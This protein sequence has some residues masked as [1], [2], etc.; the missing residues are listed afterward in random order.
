MGISDLLL[1]YFYL[2]FILEEWVLLIFGLMELFLLMLMCFL[3]DIR[4][5]DLLFI[6]V[7]RYGF[8]ILMKVKFCFV[9]VEFKWEILNLINFRF[10]DSDLVGVF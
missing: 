9:V 4:V 10:V 2:N 3:V 7:I 8:F 1:K 6:I 5:L